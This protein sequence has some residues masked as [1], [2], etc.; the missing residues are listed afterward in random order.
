MPRVLVTGAT[1]FIGN[2]LVRR[3]CDMGDDVVCLVRATS[4]RSSLESLGVTFVEGDVAEGDGGDAASLRRAVEGCDVVYHVAGVTMALDGAAFHRVNEQGTRNVAAACAA[5]ATPPVLVS[6][7]SIAAAG[8]AI[9]GRPCVES[10]AVAPVSRYGRSKLAGE[11]AV[12]E[13]ADR[14]PITIVRPPIVFGEGDRSSL[15]VFASV[16]R[17]GVHLSPLWRPRSFSFIH[18][19]DLATALVAAARSGRRLAGEGLGGEKCD[20][21]YFAAADEVVTYAEFGRRVG[22]ALGLART[23]VIPNGAAAIWTVALMSEIVAHVRRRPMI[24]GFDKAR[25]AVAGSWACSSDALIRDTSWRPAE[26]LDER[27]TETAEWY[28]DRGWLPKP[29]LLVRLARR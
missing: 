8:P 17:F 14:V 24:F 15:P 22:R 25:E 5:R 28:L 29:G 4:N 23:M 2:H 20:G 16:Q 13:F 12:A 18:A 3:L 11:R 21:V 10:D 9:D 1:G 19:A 27:L 26:S 7:S 6:V